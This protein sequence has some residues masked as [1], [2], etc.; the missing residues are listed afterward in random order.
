V[1]RAR[2]GKRNRRFHRRVPRKRA[3]QPEPEPSSDW[4]ECDGQMI[5]VAGTT[6]AGF[7]YGVTAEE[8]G[9]GPDG[10]PWPPIEQP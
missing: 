8:L 4:V 7:A 3:R 5:F 1:D 10:E 2:V 9:F 6:E